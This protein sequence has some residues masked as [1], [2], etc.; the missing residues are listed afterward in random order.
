M[1]DTIGF[2]LE[3]AGRYPVLKHD[4]QLELAY[5]VRKWLD[6]PSDAGP[7]PNPIEVRG[8]RAKAQLM[9]T[10][11]RLVVSQAKRYRHIWSSQPDIYADLIQEG[12]LG[13]NRAIEKFDPTRGYCLSTY[14]IPWIRQAI[15]R[16]VP[17]IT[18]TIRRPAHVHDHQRKLTKLIASYSAEH[19]GRHPS[20][21]WLAQHSGLSESQIEA[22]VVIGHIQLVSFDQPARDDAGVER[23]SLGDLIPDASTVSPDDQLDQDHR[24]DLAHNLLAQLPE[25]DRLLLHAI[26][27]DNATHHDCRPLLNNIS[28]SAVGLR[29]SSALERARAIADTIPGA[30]SSDLPQRPTSLCSQCGEHF[31]PVL[32]N[33][34]HLCSDACRAQRRRDLQAAAKLERLLA[35]QQSSSPLLTTAA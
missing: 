7:C 32:T 2:I 35:T 9:K 5:R 8:K 10:N 33:R 4:R 29:K 12:T 26:Y 28:R 22:A 19:D 3:A 31:I 21:D 30:S 25:Q 6:W 34:Q 27:F 14:A 1:S 23:S 17:F 15:G 13:L 18:D 16:A 24:I 11:L 20:R